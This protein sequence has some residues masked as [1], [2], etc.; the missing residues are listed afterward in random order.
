MGLTPRRQLAEVVASALGDDEATLP[1]SLFLLGQPG[2]SD[3][4]IRH[5]DRSLE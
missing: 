2:V 4:I 1:C 5:G 3:E